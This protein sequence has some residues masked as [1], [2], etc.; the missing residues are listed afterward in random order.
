M[1]EKRLL[2]H[3]VNDL[4]KEGFRKLWGRKFD[5]GS[6][7]IQLFKQI[8]HPYHWMMLY[9]DFEEDTVEVYLKYDGEI[10]DLTKK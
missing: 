6:W 10:C 2:G 5:G 9:Q 1:P 3:L 7:G 4:K 8:K